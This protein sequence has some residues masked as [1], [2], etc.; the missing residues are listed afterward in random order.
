MYII[1]VTSHEKETSVIWTVS[2]KQTTDDDDDLWYCHCWLCYFVIIIIVSCTVTCDYD[3]MIVVFCCWF[4]FFFFP[5][6]EWHSSRDWHFEFH[7]KWNNN[8]K[9]SRSMAPRPTRKKENQKGKNLLFRFLSI[10]FFQ[11]RKLKKIWMT[12]GKSKWAGHSTTKIQLWLIGVHII[13]IIIPYHS[14]SISC[15]VSLCNNR[16]THC[17]NVWFSQRT[18]Q[19]SRL[20]KKCEVFMQDYWFWVQNY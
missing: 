2:N 11:D 19:S 16:I 7:A 9:H 13:I 6:S 4:L 12:R 17:Q 1:Q 10:Q 15:S 18:F 14:S 5:V 3:L 20:H 8:R